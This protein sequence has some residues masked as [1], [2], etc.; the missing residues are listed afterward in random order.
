MRS[1]GEQVTSLGVYTWWRVCGPVC[2][3]LVC[4]EPWRCVVN[5]SGVSKKG[6]QVVRCVGVC[7]CLCADVV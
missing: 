4:V 2:M 7:F 5:V 3:L 1:G 6:C